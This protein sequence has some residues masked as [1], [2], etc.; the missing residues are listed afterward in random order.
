AGQ[1]VEIRTD[2]APKP[3]TYSIARAPDEQGLAPD[4]LLEFFVTRH[5]GGRASGWLHAKERLGAPLAIHGPYGSFHLPRSAEGPVLCLAG[6]S[7]LSPILS[8]V[9]RALAAGF[10]H[11]IR[12]IL[13]VR[14]QGEVFALDALHAL[15]RRHVNF[16]YALTLTRAVSADPAA[17]WRHGRIPAWLGEEF[18]GL[19]DHWVLAAGA[20]G[21]VDACVEKA[22]ALGA[23]PE[24]IL[25]DSF[26]PTAG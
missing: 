10:A 26:T 21:F 11:P 15:A 25:T 20:P 2:G 13:S 12:I 23:S 4:G 14:D 9:R 8:I 16:S 1:H 3:R 22:Q 5:E 17:G 19:D 18:P 6:G 24:R 7:G